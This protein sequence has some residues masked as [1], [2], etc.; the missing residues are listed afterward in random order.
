M[1][2]WRHFVDTTS[3]GDAAAIPARVHS[4]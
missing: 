1:K 2:H 4:E 3:A